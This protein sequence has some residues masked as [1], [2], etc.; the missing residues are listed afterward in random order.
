MILD[1]VSPLIDD[2]HVYVIYKN[3]HFLPSRGSVSGPH[4]LI[5][6]ALHCPLEEKENDRGWV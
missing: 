5:H 4:P 6:I 1:L 2:R 3:G